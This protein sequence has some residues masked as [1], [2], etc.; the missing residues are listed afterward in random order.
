MDPTGA[1][2]TS[3]HHVVAMP[4]PL[5]GHINAMMSLCKLLSSRKHNLLITFVVT[6]EWLHCI[7]S[8]P[9]PDKIRFASIPTVIERAKAV[10]FCGFYE[11]IKTKMEAP[12]EQLLDQLQPP[13]DRIIA[14][15]ELQWPFGFRTRRN[16]PLASLWTMSASFFSA[17]HHYHVFTQAQPEHL[18]LHLID[19]GDDIPG[20][21]STHVEDLRTVFHENDPRGME[22]VLECISKGSKAQY[23]LIN[24]VYELEP[25]A[26][27]SLKAKF[28]FPVYPIGPA[29]RYLEFKVEHSS[30]TTTTGDNRPDYLKW[31]DLQSAG[32]VLYISL[33]SFFVVSNTQMDEFATALRISGVRFLWVARGEASWLKENCGDKGLVLPWCDQLK[34]L[35]HPSLG[36][37][38][39]HCGWNSTQ[40]AVYAGIPM[41]TFPLFL[42]Q[43]PNSRQIVEDWK[44][45]WRV[46]RSELGNEILVAKEDILQLIKRFMDLESFE[47]KNARKRAGELKDICHQAITEGGSSH[48]HLDAFVNDFLKGNNH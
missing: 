25:H 12:F 43:V 36:G 20:I 42:D 3:V 45:G 1:E 44:I 30:S 46:K 19:H 41:L 18:P 13:V 47:V 17:L 48:S 23:L 29:I 34:V 33:G 8:E 22:M 38:W 4:F 24:S 39:S 15:F 16:I 28:P 6:E 32:S 40:E 26:F 11:V 37:F 9:K 10:D 5:Q 2:L 14:D 21:P 7:G 31:L 35:C 27:N